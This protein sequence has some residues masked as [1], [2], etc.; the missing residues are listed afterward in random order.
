LGW[1]SGV[2]LDQFGS[3]VWGRMPSCAEEHEC[4]EQEERELHHD[5]QPKRRLAS[6]SN[7]F[8]GAA[9][10]CQEGQFWSA[11]GRTSRN[12]TKACSSQSRT[13]RA[14]AS[15]VVYNLNSR[16]NNGAMK[17]VSIAGQIRGDGD[18]STRR[19]F[20]ENPRSHWCSANERI[21][22]WWDISGV[23]GHCGRTQH[24]CVIVFSVHSPIRGAKEGERH[25]LNLV[26]IANL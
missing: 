20:L 23:A 16:G 10:E 9:K 4:G 19:R 11:K 21:N 12:T 13:A 8:F 15:G 25:T 5:C 18:L 17:P 6:G 3:I 7:T 22:A 1:A 2:A 24:A 26:A 14:R